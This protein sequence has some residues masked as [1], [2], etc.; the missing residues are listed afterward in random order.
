M[1][2]RRPCLTVHQVLSEMLSPI[3]VGYVNSEI[4]AAMKSLGRP[5]P[6]DRTEITFM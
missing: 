6:V 1:F 2:M 4:I 3:R 5:L